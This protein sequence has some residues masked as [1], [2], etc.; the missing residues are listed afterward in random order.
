MQVENKDTSVV[1]AE[2]DAG[3]ER[4]NIVWLREVLTHDINEFHSD[5]GPSISSEKG[6]PIEIFGCLKMNY[7]NT[8]LIIQICM[9]LQKLGGS[10]AFKPTNADEIKKFLAINLLMGIKKCPSYKRLLVIISC[11]L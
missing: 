5:P 7:F 1:A 6:D 3:E 8:L 11:P 10:T 2:D 9:L 4:R